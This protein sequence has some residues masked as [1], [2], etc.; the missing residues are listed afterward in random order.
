M[1]TFR[2]ADFQV[3]DKQSHAGFERGRKLFCAF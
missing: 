1:R 3:L 2:T